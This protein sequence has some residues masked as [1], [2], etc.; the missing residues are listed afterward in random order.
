MNKKI[1]TS[2]CIIAVLAGYLIVRNIKRSSGYPELPE[3]KDA[4]GEI[5]IKKK[6]LSIVIRSKDGKWLLGSEAYPADASLVQN[7][8]AMVKKLKITDLISSQGFYDKYDLTPENSLA[9]TVSRDGKVLR[10]V[11]VGKKSSTNR[12]SYVRIDGKPEIYLVSETFDS[13]L[14]KTAEDL[15]DRKIMDV[16]KDAISSFEIRYRGAV[17]N[18]SK[19]IEEKK[20]D[21]AGKNP[22][23]DK[24][25]QKEKAP[26]KSERWVCKGYEQAPLSSENVEALL[27]GFSPLVAADFPRVEKKTLSNPQG[28]VRFRA[29][30]RDVSVDIYGKGKDNKYTAASSESPYVFTLDEWRAK[31]FLLE[32]I[33]SLKDKK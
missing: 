13:V 32:N 21:N 11:M 14:D 17:Y 15:R 31:K 1:V 12:H 8:E 28:S 2:L 6:D 24:K 26:V 29:F 16:K 30:D 33:E 4:A 10:D 25:D 19:I 9:I 3:W 5:T 27:S 20:P 22:P 7:I 23:P 18:F